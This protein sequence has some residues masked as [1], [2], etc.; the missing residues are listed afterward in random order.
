MSSYQFVNS[1]SSCYGPG[2][3]GPDGSVGAGPPADYYSQQVYNSWSGANPASNV[4]SAAAAAA[5]AVVGQ[6]P[7]SPPY[8]YLQ[9][10]GDHHSSHH[11]SHHRDL[12]NSNSCSQ[13]AA[14]GLVGQTRLSHHSSQL[15]QPSTRTSSSPS[16]CKFG[17]DS[18]SSPQDLSTSSGGAGQSPEPRAASPRVQGNSNQN[19]SQSSNGT[20]NVGNSQKGG[21]FN[22]NNSSSNPPHIYPW[23]RKVHVGQNGV[24]SM[25]ETKRQ[26]TS[27]TRYQTL[28]LEKEFHFN[29]YLT[30][31][32]RIEIA[33]S[34][35]LSERQIKIWFQNRRMKWKKEHKMQ[36]VIPPQLPQMLGPLDHHLHHLHSETK[37]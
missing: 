35:C 18:A 29:R 1:L 27:Y 9:Q 17:L 15:M 8:S 31:R 19:S 23:M 2:R 34:L 3:A 26:R 5:A 7:S 16:S 30:R 10:N 32:R 36:S 25:G 6:T 37:A 20:G 28:E 33:H 11:L 22:S 14:A 21:N 24:N 12:Y 13:Q 4:V